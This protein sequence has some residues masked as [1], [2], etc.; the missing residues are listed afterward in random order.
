MAG[1]ADTRAG[2]SLES[3]LFGRVGDTQT[4]SGLT[5]ALNR[6]LAG[7]ADTRAGAAQESDLFGTNTTQAGVRDTLGGQGF[8]DDL[9]TSGVNR[10]VTTNADTRAAAAQDNAFDNEHITQLLAAAEAGFIDPVIARHEILRSLGLGG[11]GTGVSAG[12][13]R[14]QTDNGFAPTGTELSN[15]DVLA[16]N[17]QTE[18]DQLLAQIIQSDGGI[19][20]VTSRDVESQQL[21]LQQIIDAQTGGGTFENDVSTV[22]G[23]TAETGALSSEETLMVRDLV[24]QG[25]TQQEAVATVLRIRD[26]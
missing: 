6:L 11:G 16:Q 3:D 18:F 5:N 7:N 4:E 12:D 9:L 10:D 17:R 2:Q 24:A 1:N 19:D 22:E 13:G 8:A 21:I 25:Q 26:R 23:I 14:T 20:K 15:E